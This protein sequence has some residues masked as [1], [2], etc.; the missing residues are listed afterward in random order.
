MFEKYKKSKKAVLETTLRLL[1]KHD[2]QATSMSL[3]S[4][5]SGVSMGSI[6]NSFSGKEEIINELYTSIVEY[7]T[8]YVLQGFND[9]ADLFERFQRTWQRVVQSSVDNPEAFQ[10][11]E[12]YSLSSYIYDES[13]RFAYE[14]NWCGPLAV[15]YADAMEQQIFKQSDARL[16]VQMHWG[17]FVFLVKG[18]LQGNLKLTSEVLEM[19]VSSSWNSVS[20]VKAFLP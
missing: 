7:Q 19:A 16:M 20:T 4:S 18:H 12:Q 5:E 8:E 1:S 9:S 2:L 6:Y 13:K 14:K 11:M 3:I 15:M 17:T 10:F